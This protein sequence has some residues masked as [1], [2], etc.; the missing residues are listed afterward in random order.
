MS[1][2]TFS[3]TCDLYD[4]YLEQARVPMTA[5]RHYGGRRHFCGSAITVKCFEDNSRVRELAQIPSP[6]QVMVVDGGGSLRCAL[7]GDVIAG[8]AQKSG[9]EGIIVFGAIRDAE[10]LAKLDIG[11][12]ALFSTP[13]KSV[14]KDAGETGLTVD[15]GDVACGP[16]DRVFS[17]A[18][19]I[20][21]LDPSE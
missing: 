6:G 21:I 8:M 4:I 11:I 9:W 10:A 1:S 12:M 7:V 2:E 15:L 5:F 14:R 20:L 16:G 19:G 18:D 3:S 17:D 13:R